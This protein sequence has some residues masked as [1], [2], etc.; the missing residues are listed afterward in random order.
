MLYKTP[1]ASDFSL[2]PECEYPRRVT[3]Y[4]DI[5]NNQ[6]VFVCQIEVISVY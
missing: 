5:W 3:L 1:F 6:G 2:D 4:P